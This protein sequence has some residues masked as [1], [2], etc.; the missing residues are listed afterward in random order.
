V[1]GQPISRL[2]RLATRG[3]IGP[4]STG[5]DETSQPE[6]LRTKEQ[7]ATARFVRGVTLGLVLS[8][9]LWIGILWLLS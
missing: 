7:R 2:G 3:N 4:W 6:P 1:A 8:G 5:S 9:L